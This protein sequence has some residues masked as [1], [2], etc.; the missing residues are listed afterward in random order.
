MK[1]G[2]YDQNEVT[3][4][5]KMDYKNL[6]PNMR[7]QIAYRILYKPHPRTGERYCIYPTYDYSHCLID[8]IEHV[9]H[10][11]CSLEFENRRDSY[12]WVLEVLDYYKPFV[13]EFSRLNLTHTIMSKR[14]LQTLV[15]Q[16]YVTGWDDPR[17][18]TIA[19]LRRKGFT[20]TA[21]VEFASKVSYT[22]NVSSLI[23]V[24]ALETVQRKE[25]DQ[26]SFRFFC[27]LEPLKVTVLGF[28][29]SYEVEAPLL[30]KNLTAGKR[31]MKV[32][33]TIW[34]D[35]SDFMENPTAD[36]KRLSSSGVVG[37]KYANV[38][39]KV[40]EIKKEGTEIIELICEKVENVKAPV[41]IHWVSDDYGKAEVRLFDDLFSTANVAK[42]GD[43]W[44]EDLNPLSLVVKKNCLIEKN[45]VSLDRSSHFQFE[46]LGYFY[47]DEDSTEGNLIINRT[48]SLFQRPVEVL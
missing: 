31:K 24:G 35:K 16:K 43:N 11:L 39:L 8:S 37:L 34:I 25:F 15:E 3:L 44:L 20:S 42:V 36:F 1:V 13:W 41:Y 10:S 23:S 7:D 14:R 2:Y 48:L 45:V 17:M 30:P 5:L 29:E 27:V 18:P 47:F 33:S 19:G 26:D 32:S 38:V 40:V 28:G 4:R 22:R 9:T 12:Y 6:N 21:I 46:R